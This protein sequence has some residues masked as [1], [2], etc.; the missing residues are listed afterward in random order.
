MVRKDMAKRVLYHII[1]DTELTDQ[2]SIFNPLDI[3]RKNLVSA[4]EVFFSPNNML[5]CQTALH[6]LVIK[7]S[8]AY[9]IEEWKSMAQLLLDVG[10]DPRISDNND[11]LPEDIALYRG[12]GYLQDLLKENRMKKGE[13]TMKSKIDRWPELIKGTKEND[14]KSVRQLLLDNVPILPMSSYNDPLKKAIQRG[15]IELTMLLLSA[16][17]PLCGRPLVGLNSLEIAHST[18]GL[19]VFL[20]ALIRREYYNCLRSESET[21]FSND[22]DLVQLKQTVIDF[23]ES[24]RKNG[25]ENANWNFS[26][27]STDRSERS[28]EARKMLRLAASV[29]MGLTCQILGLEDV[30]LHPLPF[31]TSPD[32]DAKPNALLIFCRDLDLSLSLKDVNISSKVKEEYEEYNFQKLIKFCKQNLI[33]FN[34]LHEKET[35][36]NKKVLQYIAEQGLDITYKKIFRGRNAQFVDLIMDDVTG[37]TML[38]SAAYNGR[39]GMVE[40][41]LFN[42][43]NEKTKTK[44]GFT[45]AHVAAMRGH[46]ECMEY[47]LAFSDLSQSLIND[48]TI[49]GLTA[50]QISDGY[51]LEVNNL[52]PFLLHVN[53]SYSI[54]S[55]PIKE[56][57]VKLVLNAKKSVLEECLVKGSLDHIIPLGYINEQQNI[58]QQLKDEAEHFIH[59]LMDADSRFQGKRMNPNGNEDA[60][61]LLL[62]DSYEI[63]LEIDNYEYW[64]ENDLHKAFIKAGNKALQEYRVKSRNICVSKGFQPT[65]IG[66]NLFLTYCSRQITT[67][68][69][70]RVIPVLKKELDLNTEGQNLSEIFH[71]IT[72]KSVAHITGTKSGKWTYISVDIE[73]HLFSKVDSSKMQV[74]SICRFIKKMLCPHWWFPR[75]ETRRHRRQWLYNAV[76]VPSVSERLLTSCFLREVFKCPEEKWDNSTVLDRVLGVYEQMVIQAKNG[77]MVAKCFLDPGN[78]DINVSKIPLIIDFLQDLRHL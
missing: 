54:L 45:A 60:L 2:L 74:L 47:I 58:W 77:K 76:S 18:P 1:V 22:S 64:L 21:I 66:A 62:M 63:Y 24:V 12:C 57:K 35:P 19:T 5:Q 44:K 27:E 41:L 32:I 75:I 31:E 72:Q 9:S 56:N 33:N 48:Q 34:S 73:K 17:A 11:E 78:D 51:T 20:P 28:K 25:Y 70:I 6:A 65:Y 71:D 37:F 68:I 23:S 13:I 29:G 16:G 30:F 50:H 14:I 10:C 55:D 40:Y 26:S 42:K 8:K 38:H 49:S 53:E 15:N 69:S 52:S 36:V 3:I 7:A 43:A 61:E 59:N 46:K 4:L 39:M 67:H